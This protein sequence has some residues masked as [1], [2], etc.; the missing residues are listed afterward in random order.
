MGTQVNTGEHL[1]T[2]VNTREQNRNTRGTLVNT[3]GTLRNTGE[4][5]RT[6]VNTGKHE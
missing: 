6:Q 5:K 3:E 2:R 1:G 4:H